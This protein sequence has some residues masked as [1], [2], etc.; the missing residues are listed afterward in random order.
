MTRRDAPQLTVI[1]WRD[2]PAQVRANAAIAPE[3]QRLLKSE[4][5]ARAIVRGLRAAGDFEPDAALAMIQKHFG[6][7]AANASLPPPPSVTIHS[8]SPRILAASAT[9]I[10]RRIAPAVPI[11]N[12]LTGALDSCAMSPTTMPNEAMNSTI[13]MT[14]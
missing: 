8:S 2:I 6:P 12:V 7:I 13:R 5:G 11:E 1:Y 14:V 4:V 9:R 10:V 3:G